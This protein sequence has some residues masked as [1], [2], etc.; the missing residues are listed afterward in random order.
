MPRWI[1]TI[2]RT[3]EPEEDR[4]LRRMKDEGKGRDLIAR[5]LN[6]SPGSVESRMRKLHMVKGKSSSRAW[7]ERNA[8]TGPA[9][10]PLD[11]G[12]GDD[13][14]VAACLAQGGFYYTTRLPDGRLVTVRP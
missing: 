3:W 4:I 10:K 8:A 2:P 5:E 6:R 11:L 1:G 12:Q 13:R 9:G 7:S 14:Y